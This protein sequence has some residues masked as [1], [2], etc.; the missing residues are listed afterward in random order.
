MLTY[1]VHTSSTT[2]S[3]A[4]RLT[5]HLRRQEQTT[6]RGP[7]L[8]RRGGEHTTLSHTCPLLS[9]PIPAALRPLRDVPAL[10]GTPPFPLSLLQIVY[11][12]LPDAAGRRHILHAAKARMEGRGQGLQAAVAAAADSPRLSLPVTV[13]SGSTRGD[14][15]MPGK[16]E[17]AGANTAAAPAPAAAAASIG[18]TASSTPAIAGE[19]ASMPPRCQE[20]SGTGGGSGGGGDGSSVAIGG[21]SGGGRW[22]SDVDTEWLSQRTNGYSGADLSSLVRNAAMVA[23]REEGEGQGGGGGEA[24]RC[25]ESGPRGGSGAAGGRTGALVLARRHFETALASTQPSSAPETV[26]KHE[27]WA[28]QWRV[29]S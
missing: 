20:G 29:S 3:S 9:S 8:G 26:A 18:S 16:R 15:A 27:R 14:E 22:A 13:A 1:L 4:V 19:C 17:A 10:P 25:R 28:R 23:L 2:G 21:G 11:A 5:R 7:F 24:R 6:A 12:G